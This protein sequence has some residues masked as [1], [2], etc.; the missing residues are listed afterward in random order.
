MRSLDLMILGVATEEG[1]VPFLALVTDE[2]ELTS[3]VVDE[4]PWVEGH[5]IDI[6]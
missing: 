4:T 2:E 1:N 5:K 3:K 6:H